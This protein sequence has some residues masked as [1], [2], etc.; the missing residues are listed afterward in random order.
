MTQFYIKPDSS[1]LSSIVKEIKELLKSEE[2]QIDQ[3]IAYTG[4]PS[5]QVRAGL[6]V[7]ER[8]QEVTYSNKYWSLQQ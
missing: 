1:H 4:Y 2:L 7:L 3:L 8:R 6:E 5:S